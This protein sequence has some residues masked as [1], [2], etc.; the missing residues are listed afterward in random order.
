V[1]LSVITHFSFYLVNKEPM[2]FRFGSNVKFGGFLRVDFF[3]RQQRIEEDEQ[4]YTAVRSIEA[5]GVPVGKITYSRCVKIE[6]FQRK[7]S[8]SLLVLT[9][10]PEQSMSMEIVLHNEKQQRAKIFI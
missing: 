7:N 4:Y 5:S 9:S 10:K 3:G 6:I 2:V 8:S 1:E